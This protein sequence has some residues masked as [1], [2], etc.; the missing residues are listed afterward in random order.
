MQDEEWQVSEQLLLCL[1]SLSSSVSGSLFSG[2]YHCVTESGVY[3][4]LGLLLYNTKPKSLYRC[5]LMCR[6][7]DTYKKLKGCPICTRIYEWTDGENYIMLLL[8][9]SISRK[10]CIFSVFTQFLYFQV[11]ALGLALP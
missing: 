1:S 7:K 9:L 10:I 3:S 4:L 2:P 11:C 6:S 8:Y 5:L